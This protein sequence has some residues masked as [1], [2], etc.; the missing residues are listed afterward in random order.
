MK[1]PE[2][3]WR[4]YVRAWARSALGAHAGVRDLDSDA[5]RRARRGFMAGWRA[6]KR[7][8]HEVIRP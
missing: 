8:A 7:A 4:E 5:R 3:A 1:R 2:D 6:A